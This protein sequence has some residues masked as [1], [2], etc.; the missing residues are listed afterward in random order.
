MSFGNKK[1]LIDQIIKWSLLIIAVTSPFWS[2]FLT[3]FLQTI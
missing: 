2:I 1:K 3:D